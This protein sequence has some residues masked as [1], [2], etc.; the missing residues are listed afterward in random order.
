MPENGSPL[1]EYRCY[2]E[3]DHRRTVEK[4]LQNNRTCYRVFDDTGE[5]EIP[6]HGMRS[7]H[8]HEEC[9]SIAPNDP[10]T[11]T[12]S[13]TYTCF[14]SR[15]QWEIRI[16]AESSLR[17]DADNFYL[18]ASVT[19]WEGD[20]IFSQRQWKKVIKRDFM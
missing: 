9:W 20:Q 18:K 1:P 11:S 13:S 16:V 8:T 17:C 5:Y 4:D 3:P 12:S 10:V 7:R 15:D 2:L 14:M 19:A 6:K